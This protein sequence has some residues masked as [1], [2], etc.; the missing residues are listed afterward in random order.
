MGDGC[1][2]RT[3]PKTAGVTVYLMEELGDARMRC[4]QLVR[5]VDEA[6]KLVEASPQKEAVFEAAGHLTRSIPET[7]FKLQKALQAVALAATRLDY[8]EIKQELRPEKVE[9]LEKVLQDVRIR[10]VKRRSQPWAPEEAAKMRSFAAQVRLLDEE[11][12]KMEQV[13][14]SQDPALE[15]KVGHKVQA[16]DWT[17]H[18]ANPQ[19]V[20]DNFKKENPE[21]SDADLDKFVD[22]WFKNKDVVK[23]KEA[24]KRPTFDVAKK[25]LLEHLGKE[26]WKLSS[27]SLK[28][29][30]ATNRDG[31]V[32]LWFKT[33]AVYMSLTSPGL[34]HTMDNA[35]SI[36]ADIRDMTPEQFMSYVE[37]WSKQAS[38][39]RTAC[40]DDKMSRY[41]EGKP[42][43]PTKEMSPEDAKE[44][45]ENTEE[46][47]DKFKSASEDLFWKVAAKD[48]E[49]SSKFEEGKPADP[50]E[51]MSPE[52]A[53][54]WKEEH[55]KNK[56]RFK[57]AAAP[58]G[59]AQV[60]IMEYLDSH[61]KAE[62]SDM[63]RAPSLRGVHTK[64]I[65]S[66]AEALKKS[67]LVNYDGKTIS[68]KAA[69]DAES[70][71]VN[72]ASLQEAAF[73]TA[74]LKTANELYDLS[75]MVHRANEGA[76]TLLK[77][78]MGQYSVEGAYDNKH[79]REIRDSFYNTGNAMKAA[80]RN[81]EYLAWVLQGKRKLVGT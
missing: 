30:H 16:E 37:K 77:D 10:Q 61:E 44:W 9:Q 52:D 69:D 22:Q 33:Q 11:L 67:G 24:A 3:R 21:L 40:D 29:P 59:K 39:D 19:E 73:A 14:M 76:N 31:T 49:K 18:F 75:V 72:A 64:D 23:D 38:Y 8:E 70:W 25:A 1:I 50:T 54:T 63:S 80:A 55:E 68:K 43:D 34:T 41:E 27:P 53:A 20:R 42:A 58:R 7:T 35:R 60:A 78:A 28:I 32:R 57:A 71:K 66:A 46:H 6:I 51:N 17:S 2:Q 74:L 65:M 5:Y 62:V 26:G 45:K 4:D 13:T 81:A 36:H 47:K 56:D 79:L 12:S 15:W 48:E